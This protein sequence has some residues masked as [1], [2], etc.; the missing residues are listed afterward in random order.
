MSKLYVFKK[1]ALRY[2]KYMCTV[3]GA[4]SHMFVYPYVIL[5]IWV[6]SRLYVPICFIPI[7]LPFIY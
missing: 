1:I 6:Q 2:F 7:F 4:R 3:Y 5:N